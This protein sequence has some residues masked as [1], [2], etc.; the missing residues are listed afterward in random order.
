[1]SLIFTDQGSA[2]FQP[3]Q[4]KVNDKRLAPENKEQPNTTENSAE[5]ELED[6]GWQELLPE[7]IALPELPDIEWRKFEQDVLNF[8]IDTSVP[9]HK[10][11]LKRQPRRK[12][13]GLKFQEMNEAARQRL[14]KL[15][16]D[17]AESRED[18]KLARLRV[19]R[20]YSAENF[21]RAEAL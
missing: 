3:P 13:P 8:T 4:P 11:P 5:S 10:Q 21:L 2:I 12:I 16:S 20:D 19:A 14:N 7:A 17:L 1:M 15:E 18:E 9:E 6:V